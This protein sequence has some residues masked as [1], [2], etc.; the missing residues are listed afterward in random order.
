MKIKIDITFFTNL[1]Y[2]AINY[3][4]FFYIVTN[5]CRN[6]FICIYKQHVYI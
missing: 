4:Y 3:V 1:D 5:K 6:Y 2:N